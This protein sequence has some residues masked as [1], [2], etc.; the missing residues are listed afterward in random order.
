MQE[1]HVRGT[2]CLQQGGT[3]NRRAQLD[4]VGTRGR[5]GFLQRLA[6]AAV[7]DHDE[8]HPRVQLPGHARQYV[9]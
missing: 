3:R 2:V 1:Q 5:E 8:L 7:A 6:P 9:M 4:I